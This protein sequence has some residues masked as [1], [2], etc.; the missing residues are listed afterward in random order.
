MSSPRP[1]PPALLRGAVTLL[2]SALLLLAVAAAGLDLRWGTFHQPVTGLLLGLSAMTTAVVL[3]ALPFITLCGAGPWSTACAGLCAAVA[4]LAFTTAVHLRADHGASSAYGAFEPVALLIVLAFTARRGAAAPAAV[5]TVALIAAVVSRPLAVEVREG[6]VIVAFILTLIAVAVAGAAVTARLVAAD[7]RQREYRIRLEQRMRL[8]R[9]LHDYVAHHVTGMVVQA[10]GA[11]AIADKR[12]DLVPAALRRIEDTGA[13]AIVSLRRMV[14]AL[15]ADDPGAPVT[16]PGGMT[17]VR[18]LVAGFGL[19]GVSVRLVEDGP[20][21]QLPMDVAAIVH[22]VVME[23][24]TNIRKHAPAC[25][26]VAVRV[27]A[28]QRHVTVSVDNDG[29]AGPTAPPG[30]GLTGLKERVTSA[31]GSLRTGAGG[32]GTW[33]VHARLPLSLPFH[34]ADAA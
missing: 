29:A 4:S 34:R 23:A 11:G 15:R 26:T 12:P 31:G 18:A 33:Q 21:E 8:A 30:Y 7:R 5:G 22:R 14:G 24:L 19:V 16:P 1:R 27:Q 10:Q 20:T 25:R 6:S 28:E 13:E 9:D 17:A 3:L 2:W 32:D